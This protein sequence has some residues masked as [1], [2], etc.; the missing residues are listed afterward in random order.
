MFPRPFAFHSR[1]FIISLLLSCSPPT[2]TGAV[3]TVVIYTVNSRAWWSRP[4]IAKERLEI[5]PGIADSYAPSTP[6]LVSWVARVLTALQ[7]ALPSLVRW[8]TA[9]PVDRT[10]FVEVASAAFNCTVSQVSDAYDSLFAA[11]AAAFPI[12]QTKSILMRP[13]QRN[14]P[15]VTV[16]SYVYRFCHHPP[17]DVG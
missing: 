4:H 2:V 5:V 10:R 17:L 11:I 8:R 15:T 3:I 6:I 9:L 14:E 13:I 1:S 7:H 12:P 16:V